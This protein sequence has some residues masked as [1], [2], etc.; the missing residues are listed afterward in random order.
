MGYQ[1]PLH[2]ETLSF[3]PVP[4]PIMGLIATIYVLRR[5][6]KR[7]VMHN[8]RKVP[9][10]YTAL[11]FWGSFLLL[12]FGLFAPI[13][14]FFRDEAS[15]WPS[16]TGI[17]ANWQSMGQALLLGRANLDVFR[18]NFELLA[19]VILWVFW[20]QSRRKW[21]FWLA[22]VLYWLQL[23]YAIYEGFMRSYYLLDPVLYNDVALFDDGV[24]YALHMMNLPWII[25][26]GG[27][28]GFVALA[29]LLYGLHWLLLQRVDAAKLGLG[30]R[31]GLAGM[32]AVAVVA[33]IVGK[34]GSGVET[35]VSSFTVKIIQNVTLS[36]TAYAEDLRFDSQQ[37]FPFYEFTAYDL[38]QKP[39]IHVLFIE[40]YGSVLYQRADFRRRY[41][42]L[43]PLLEEQLAQENWQVA[44]NRSIAPI[45]G[46]GS[47]IAYTSFLTGLQI[48]SH[49]QYLKL[50]D[51]YQ[52]EAF[53]HLFNYLQTQGYRRYRLSSNSDE[54]SDAQ[55]QQ[56]KN[57]YGVD[58]W[59]RF[60]DMQYSGPLY[61]WGPAPPDQYAIHYSYEF[62]NQKK[63]APYVFFF[64]SQNSHY[65]WN[66]LPNFV[67]DWRTLNSTP[68]LPDEPEITIPHAELRGRYMA[69]IEYELTQ[70][71]DFI[72]GN[73]DDD[74]IFILVGDHQPSRVA[75][76]DDGQDTFI[77]VISKDAA[78][79]EAFYEFGFIP[80]L[81]TSTVEPTMH[82]AGFYTLFMR[83]LL[84]QYGVNQETL[85]DYLPEGVR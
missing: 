39:N 18:L 64:I 60:S 47:W 10:K 68:P 38:A 16:G 44:S 12:N 35:A 66:P 83:I 70:L 5:L 59:L 32:L 23:A 82:H 81:A 3:C 6:V 42:I 21:V 36:R 24:E 79:I 45:W 17:G 28:V 29:A 73:G 19:V 58:E 11:A 57:F 14:L 67:G 33:L 43:L 20:P 84:Q 75:R 41:G 85:P 4:I 71:V 40:S 78:L 15:F 48:E 31:V 56:Y 22:F 8:W 9:D 65:P 54:I 1:M 51:R 37:L 52:E 46:G 80:G 2:D 30:T 61:G 74:D 77:H 72:I 62:I 49:A 50:F 63:D 13:F 76:R 34:E 55:W 7:N 53:P 26:L 69:S 25:Y 27:A